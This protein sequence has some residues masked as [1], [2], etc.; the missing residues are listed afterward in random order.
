MSGEFRIVLQ[1][2]VIFE[3]LLQL[4]QAIRQP[5]LVFR[6]GL[7]LLRHRLQHAAHG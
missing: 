1:R 7:L 3:L 6:H 2:R 4:F 5:A